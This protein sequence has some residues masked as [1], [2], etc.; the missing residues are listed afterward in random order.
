MEEVMGAQV[1]LDVAPH[2]ALAL[3]SPY[4]SSL[5]AAAGGGDP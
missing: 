4:A 3:T 2:G 1:L 5:C